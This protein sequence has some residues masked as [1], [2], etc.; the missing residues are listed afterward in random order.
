MN[1][2]P[3][4]VINTAPPE[5][6][7]WQFLTP[8]G[9]LQIGIQTYQRAHRNPHFADY[10]DTHTTLYFD[11]QHVL[12]VTFPLAVWVPVGE[13]QRE[14][15]SAWRP[16]FRLS[17]A[18]LEA[19]RQAANHLIGRPYDLG[20]NLDIALDE[21]LGVPPNQYRRF[22]DFGRGLLTC[23]NGVGAVFTA[24]ALEADQAGR[25]RPFEGSLF[26]EDGEPLDVNRICPACYA[27]TPE[28]FQN[29]GML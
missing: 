8:A 1:L 28:R 20:Q 14:I 27:N 17:D 4:D 5:H 25:P 11:P 21:I 23:S 18:D 13:I 15:W 3:G 19:M 26:Q 6:H 7:W 24:A 22:F 12:S 16:V 9:A 10:W 2:R 29:V